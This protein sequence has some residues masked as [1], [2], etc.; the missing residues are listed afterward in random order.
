MLHQLI[1][2][3]SGQVFHWG[4]TVPSGV[5]G[6]APNCIFVDDNATGGEGVYVN[7]GSRT[8]C[9]FGR[10]GTAGAANTFT[11]TQTFSGVVVLDAGDGAVAADAVLMGVGTTGS[12]STS[13]TANAK[14]IEL[15]AS[16]TAAASSDARGIYVRF[17]FD[18]EHASAGG[19]AI[20]G[21]SVVN[22]NIG[23]AHGAHFGLAFKAEAGGSECAGLGVGLRG[24]LQI[25]A[26]ASWAPAGTYAAGMFEIYSDSSASDPAGMTELSVLRLCNSGNA[27]GAADVDTDAHIFS[28]QGFTAAADTTSALSSVSLAELPTCIGI[29]VKVGA[30]LYYIPAVA[31]AGWN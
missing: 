28:I 11:A 22:E 26:I 6:Y 21:L 27:T 8:S 31:V 20:R 25:P 13:A 15:R 19:E 24:T 14:F 1:Q 30:S 12:P 10:I 17:A 18:G 16:T 3:K 2:G 29:R 5:A 9:T 23:T 7:T 4:N